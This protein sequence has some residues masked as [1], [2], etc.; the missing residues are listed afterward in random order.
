M[1]LEVM[2]VHAYRGQ[3]LMAALCLIFLY[4]N[5]RCSPPSIFATGSLAELETHGLT[6]L[7]GHQTLRTLLTPSPSHWNSRGVLA[8]PSFY[9]GAGDSNLYSEHII[10]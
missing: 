6:R 5:Q 2:C 4:I 7:T 3:K 8:R 1:H 9:V 10:H